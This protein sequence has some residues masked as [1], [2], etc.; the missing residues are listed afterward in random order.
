MPYIIQVL[1]HEPFALDAPYAVDEEGARSTHET[2][3][4][5]RRESLFKRS[6]E[7]MSIEWWTMVC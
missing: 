5:G 1:M 6:E 4:S 3:R 7:A 2:T